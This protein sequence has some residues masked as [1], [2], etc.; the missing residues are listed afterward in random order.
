[1][2]I[3]LDETLSQNKRGG[4]EFKRLHNSTP[5]LTPRAKIKCPFESHDL[6]NKGIGKHRIQTGMQV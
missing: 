5:N 4:V 3:E 6:K 2:G 1:M